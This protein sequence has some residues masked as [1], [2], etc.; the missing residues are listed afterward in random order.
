[1]R[2]DIESSQHS[3]IE[4]LLEHGPNNDTK[5]NLKGKQALSIAKNMDT[6]IAK[7]IYIHTGGNGNQAE[8]RVV[9][10]ITELQA[11]SRYKQLFTKD[12][13]YQGP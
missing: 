13:K 9:E 10:T 2:V 3:C 6:I 7:G 5:L 1:M 4:F 8:T 11:R 12:E